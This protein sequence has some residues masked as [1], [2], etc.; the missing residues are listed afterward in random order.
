MSKTYAIGDIHG[1]YDLLQKALSA[2]YSRTQDGNL[3]HT[4]VFL[5]DYVD[6]G[7]QSRLVVERLMLGARRAAKWVVLKGNHELMLAD[8]WENG[9]PLSKDDFLANGGGAT[10]LSYGH[11][12]SSVRLDLTVIPEAHIRW[13]ENLPQTYVD[14]HRVYV[15]AALDPGS[16][17]DD[18]PSEY[19]LWYIY[20]EGVQ[21]VYPDYHV[22]RG[23]EQDPDGPQ[24]WRGRTNLDTSAFRTGRL[25]I[26]VFDDD[27]PGG[28]TGSIEVRA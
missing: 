25:V 5:G 3:P 16:P 6:R 22:V 19:A 23:H 11:P 27:T 15:H 7:P 8:D 12:N 2:I 4:V 14:D 26:G 1:R 28:P 9:M 17:P 10:L 21:D 18:Q 20:P 13:M 24:Y